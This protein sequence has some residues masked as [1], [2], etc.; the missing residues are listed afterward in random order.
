M[1]ILDQNLLTLDFWQDKVTYAGHTPAHRQHRLC[2]YEHPRRRNRAAY[3]ACRTTGGFC[4]ACCGGSTYRR[5]FHGGRGKCFENH[6][7]DA[8]PISL[9]SS[10]LILRRPR[11]RTSTITLFLLSVKMI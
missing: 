8:Y 5:T 9:L 6:A 2:R 11:Q 10:A 1:S 4:S 7:D 3:P